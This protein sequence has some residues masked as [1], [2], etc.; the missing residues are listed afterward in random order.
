[1]FNQRFR[2][3]LAAQKPEWNIGIILP[4]VNTTVA[5]I[6]EEIFD[7]QEGFKQEDVPMLAAAM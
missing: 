2:K 5:R 7:S 3:M 4:G 6:I 1:M